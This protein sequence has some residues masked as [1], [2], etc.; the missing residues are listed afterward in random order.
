MFEL[1]EFLGLF[2]SFQA[3]DLFVFLFCFVFSELIR[4]SSVFKCFF[5]IPNAYYSSN[6]FGNA[7]YSYN[8]QPAYQ[9]PQQVVTKPK[10]T[11]YQYVSYYPYLQYNQN[12]Q[13]RSINAYQPSFAPVNTLKKDPYAANPHVSLLPSVQ[14]Y[15]HAKY[16]PVTQN[17]IHSTPVTGKAKT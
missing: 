17:Y 1:L 14:T 8:G 11:S 12:Y 7:W 3:F 4:R 6:T 16:T 9:Y 5:Q 10:T 13:Y 2:R 15:S